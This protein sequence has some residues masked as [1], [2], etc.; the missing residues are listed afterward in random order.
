[1]SSKAE[2]KKIKAFP[3]PITVKIGAHVVNGQVVKMGKLGLMI[4]TTSAMLSVGDTVEA[5]FTLPVI[6]EVI[7]CTGLIVKLINQMTGAGGLRIAEMH[8]KLIP[9]LARERVMN[10]LAAAGAQE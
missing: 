6:K 10:Y 4:E 1:V 9:D 7:H 5:E 2:V 8:F 3:F